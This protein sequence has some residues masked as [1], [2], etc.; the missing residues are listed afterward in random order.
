MTFPENDFSFC[1]IMG[2]LLSLLKIVPAPI[3]L[4]YISK[5]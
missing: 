3:N 1:H 4:S 5:N 2:D